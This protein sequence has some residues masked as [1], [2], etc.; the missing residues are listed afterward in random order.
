V[1]DRRT[2]FLIGA[3]ALAA[4]LLLAG[5]FWYLGSTTTSGGEPSEGMGHVARSR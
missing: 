4:A 2:W 1:E 3:I 5:F